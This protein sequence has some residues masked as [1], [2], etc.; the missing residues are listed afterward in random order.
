MK[1]IILA[2]ILIAASSHASAEAPKPALRL[3]WS[4]APVTAAGHFSEEDG[5]NLWN[6]RYIYKDYHT[7]VHSAGNFS[8]ICDLE[9]N[10][11]LSASMCFA[12]SGYSMDCYEGRS[13]EKSHVA[14]GSAFYLVPHIRFTY[15]R[16]DMLRAYGTLGAGYCI[17]SG[18]ETRHGSGVVQFNPAGIEYGNKL[19]GFAELGFGTMFI[20]GHIGIVYK[21]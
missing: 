1:R 11:W 6:L 17:Y 8:A 20:G 18:F 13:G 19:F 16:N 4:M 21:F 5:S 9:F 3:G 2:L 10:E 15:Y 12:Y 7:D 14:K